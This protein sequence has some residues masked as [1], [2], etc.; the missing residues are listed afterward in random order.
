MLQKAM[1]GAITRQPP[2]IKSIIGGVWSTSK[3]SCKQVIRPSSSSVSMEMALFSCTICAVLCPSYGRILEA[4][5][6]SPMPDL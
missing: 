2:I 1:N 5:A 6:R 4:A 3:P